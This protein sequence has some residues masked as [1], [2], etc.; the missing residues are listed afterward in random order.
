M[1]ILGISGFESS[2][3]FKKAHW[4]GLPEREYRISQGHDSAAALIVDGVWVGAAAE[5]RFT[6]KKHTGDFPLHAIR[7]CLQEANLTIEDVDE[8]AHGFDYAPYERFYSF[9]AVARRRYC[10]VYSREALLRL[11]SRDLP[12]FPLERVYHVDHHLAHAASAYCTSGWDKCLIVVTDGMGELH[13]S[14]PY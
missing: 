6:R 4:P 7:Y 8:I 14:S 12:G 11:V 5:E 10:E 1:R 2:I 13:S 3:P 9:D